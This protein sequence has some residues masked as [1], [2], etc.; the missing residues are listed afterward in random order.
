MGSTT[1]PA[2]VSEKMLWTSYVLSALPVLMLLMSAVMKFARPPAVTEGFTHL[3][4][5]E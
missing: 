4:W 2:P 3:G 5:P 1:T